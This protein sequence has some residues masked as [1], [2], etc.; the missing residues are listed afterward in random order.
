MNTNRL[1]AIASVLI[2]AVLLA[3]TFLLAVSPQLDA[4]NKA[5]LE[6]EAVAAQNQ[7]ER[8]K[9]K[10]LEDQDKDRAS[11]DAQVQ[12]LQ[13]G[14]PVEPDLH[15]L[16]EQLNA[17]GVASGAFLDQILFDE[18]FRYLPPEGI[19]PQLA[20]AASSIASGNL[21]V[22]PITIVVNS[23][24][25]NVVMDFLDRLQHS[26]R[27]FLAYEYTITVEDTGQGL[28]V[29]MVIA[30]EAYV[31]TDAP[32]AEQPVTTNPDGTVTE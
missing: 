3:G 32:A 12:K 14:I 6:R 2:I 29:K 7:V 27:I 11:I 9:I 30:G 1:W 4:M 23:P 13:A 18:S 5:N 26:K 8:A 22:L 20:D 21:V 16:I 25:Y 28:I 19:D 24:D 10:T 17:L 31:L 15:P